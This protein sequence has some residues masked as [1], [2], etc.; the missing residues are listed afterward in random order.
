M[1][2]LKIVVCMKVVPKPEEVGVDK[3]TMRL[4]RE[5]ARSEMNPTDMNAL[6]MALDFKD[7]HGGSID[8]VSMG[9]PF[10]SHFLPVGLAMGANHIYLLSH[11]GLA[12]QTRS[13]QP[14]RWPRASARSATWI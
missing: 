6:E 2:D 8:I 10:F 7:R 5:N 1:S 3:E 14:T 12:A 11:R 4:D 9:P 13:L